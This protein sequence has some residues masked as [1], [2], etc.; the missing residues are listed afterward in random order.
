MPPS[1]SPSISECTPPPAKITTSTA[2][3][4]EVTMKNGLIGMRTDV[5][6]MSRK[7]PISTTAAVMPPIHMP[8]A[9]C[10]IE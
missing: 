2:S 3:S 5:N 7:T 6:R 8:P 10:V 1:A 9:S 4:T